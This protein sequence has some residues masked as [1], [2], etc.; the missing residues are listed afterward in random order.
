MANKPP[1]RRW[2]SVWVVVRRGE[3]TAV[4]GP[5]ADVGLVHAGCDELVVTR[6]VDTVDTVTASVIKFQRGIMS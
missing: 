6:E 5:D 4:H 2:L 1:G 3:R